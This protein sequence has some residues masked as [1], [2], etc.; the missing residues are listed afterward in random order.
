[1]CWYVSFFNTVGSCIREPSP[2][3][4]SVTHP[5]DQCNPGASCLHTCHFAQSILRLGNVKFPCQL[6][7]T[8][9]CCKRDRQVWRL[10]EQRRLMESLTV[11]MLNSIRML[12]YSL[13]DLSYLLSQ[14]VSAC[15]WIRHMWILPCRHT[16]KHA[17]QLIRNVGV[18][19]MTDKLV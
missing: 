7:H 3:R 5:A 13:S 2:M 14:P 11:K 15:W 18:E 9:R 16:D 6:C 4:P 17:G 12:Q 1:M 19:D 10:K 8:T